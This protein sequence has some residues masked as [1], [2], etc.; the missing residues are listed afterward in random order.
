MDSMGGIFH[1]SAHLGK[2]DFGRLDYHLREV[3]SDHEASAVL[4]RRR[5]VGVVFD[6]RDV[7]E[8]SRNSV[9][10]LGYL[11]GG[12]I[13]VT[14]QLTEHIYYGN[15]SLISETRV[16]N[17]A[18]LV[19]EPS[20]STFSYEQRFR[21]YFAYHSQL[22]AMMSNIYVQ[23]L[24]MVFGETSMQSCC[25]D[26]MFSITIDYSCILEARVRAAFC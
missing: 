1:T 25:S 26:L 13:Q 4:L 23:S 2:K 8:L 22:P 12:D 17:G 18:Q 9:Q 10:K 19:Q 11:Q 24:S 3:W 14:T 21:H 20:L 7:D 5:D 16:L 15:K 6:G